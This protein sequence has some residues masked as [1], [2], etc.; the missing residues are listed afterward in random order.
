MI[1]A[2]RE[3]EKTRDFFENKK[4]E[5]VDIYQSTD[6]YLNVLKEDGYISLRQK[7]QTNN[8]INQAMFLYEVTKLQKFH[9]SFLTKKCC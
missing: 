5:T 2:S 6:F 1:A 3:P 7:G 9:D 4:N 8:A